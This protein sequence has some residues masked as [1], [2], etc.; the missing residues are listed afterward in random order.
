M[1]ADKSAETR[2]QE[3]KKLDVDI[4]Q[5]KLDE[6]RETHES[7]EEHKR[8]AQVIT[9]TVREQLLKPLVKLRDS[10][11]DQ[12]TE[13]YVRRMVTR[14]AGNIG[15][16]PEL[17]QQYQQVSAQ[18]ARS[19]QQQKNQL[20]DSLDGL[21]ASYFEAMKRHA[22][23]IEGNLAQLNI[24]LPELAL[25][26]DFD[27]SELEEHRRRSMKLN[28]EIE[29][30]QDE[31]DRYDVE[32]ANNAIDKTKRQNAEAKLQ[33]IQRQLE[34]MGSAP[35]P[36]FYQEK[37]LVSDWGSGFLWLSE[38]YEMVTRRDDSKVRQYHAERNEFRAGINASA[39]EL[40]EIQ[41]EEFQRTGRRVS[42][43]AAKKKYEREMER[44]E[45]EL[46]RA[47]QQAQQ[48]QETLIQDTLAQLRRN[49]LSQL[50]EGIAGIEHYLSESVQQVFNKQADLLVECVREQML[51]PLN[52]KRAQQ[53]E[54]QALLQQG[55]AQITARRTE[56]NNARRA[57]TEV[58]Q[59]THSAL[60][61]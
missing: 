59:L 32:I 22:E 14:G 10:V 6:Q 28:S 48:N 33:R 18:L 19:W 55:Q 56:L 36:V 27:F 58:Q 44:K 53:Q 51:E 38:T 37:E 46:R 61:I 3:L 9:D 35:E 49:T 47:E 16:P 42:C 20:R 25:S 11:A 5:L 40:K 30:L 17:D 23:H 29:R 26:L 15:L 4:Q 52:A 1:D 57:L 21:R 60:A 2:A 39:S 31:V 12:V 13:T 54:V 41:E 45:K 24:Q 8:A 43:E 50:N 34:N 7:R